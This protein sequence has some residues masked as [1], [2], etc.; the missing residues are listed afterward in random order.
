MYKEVSMQEKRAKFRR[1][2]TSGRNGGRNQE[3]LSTGFNF[4]D[5]FHI[6]SW[7]LATRAFIACLFILFWYM[8]SPA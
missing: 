3:G 2:A 7:V 5:M 4:T 8:L 1:G 6:A